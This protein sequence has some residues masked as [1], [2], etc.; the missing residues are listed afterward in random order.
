MNNQQRRLRR[1]VILSLILAF[2]I[3]PVPSR[4]QQSTESLP[5]NASSRASAAPKPS[6][7]ST[8]DGSELT[9][10]KLPKKFLRDEKDMWLFPAQLAQGRHWIPT[11]FIVGGTAGFIAADPALMRKFR[12]TDNFNDFNR[13][14]R[15]SVTGGLIAVVPVAFYATSLMRRDAYGQSTSLLAGEAVAHDTLLVIVT[16][17]ITRRARPSEFPPNG[18][19]NDTFFATHNSFFGKGSAFPSGH[20]MMSF[21]VATVFAQRYR[22]HKWVPFV[23][24]GLAA[25]ISFSRV[26]TGA[27]FPSDV[28]FGATLGYVIAR[29]DVLRGQ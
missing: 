25:A 17:A 22:R 13:V 4:A 10:K 5:E 2:A 9:W 1:G 14:F 24:Y 7:T 11:A 21:S 18:R 3:S 16:K 23:A 6:S 29:Y 15:S 8:K 12:Q 27:H 20:A 26:S 19:Y 28:F